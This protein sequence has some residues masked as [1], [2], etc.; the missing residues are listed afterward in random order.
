VF[1]ADDPKQVIIEAARRLDRS[2][3]ALNRLGIQFA[4]IG[5]DEDATEA[6]KELDD[7]IAAEYGVRVSLANDVSFRAMCVT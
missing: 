3:I 7:D 2:G 6:L 5:D 1:S 4:Q